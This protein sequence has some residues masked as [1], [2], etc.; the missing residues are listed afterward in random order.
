VRRVFFSHAKKSYGSPAEARS[1]AVIRDRF[2][3]CEVVDPG[4]D[5][6]GGF[7]FASEDEE[8]KHYLGIIDGC[9]SVVFSRH[10]GVVTAGVLKEVNHALAE[11]KPVYEVG[12]GGRVV[13]VTKPFA[14][15]SKA[16]AIGHILSEFVRRRDK[17]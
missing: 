11:G 14:R 1:L 13:R 5:D 12:G 8:L 4:D 15:S 17:S 2:P 16:E 9:D 3:G 7:R 10:K 6:R